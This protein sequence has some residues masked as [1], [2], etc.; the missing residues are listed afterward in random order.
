VVVSNAFA[1]SALHPQSGAGCSTSGSIKQPR[2]MESG[3]VI[4]RRDCSAG[5]LWVGV[6]PEG[7]ELGSPTAPLFSPLPSTSAETVDGT[8]SDKESEDQPYSPKA[9]RHIPI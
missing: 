8:G 2:A 3:A 4:A 7:Q 5:V 9:M 1:A 6:G